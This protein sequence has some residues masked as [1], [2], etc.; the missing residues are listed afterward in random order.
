VQ[1]CAQALC[2]EEMFGHAVPEGALFYAA[3][4]K[5]SQVAIDAE[6]RSLTLDIAR[7]TAAMIA[8]G[9]TPPPVTKSGCRRCSLVNACQPERLEKPP[10][11]Q[12]WLLRQLQDGP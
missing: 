3:T 10:S 11:V 12:R 9:E 4:K 8:I 5:R 1:L 2:L 6:L 7:R